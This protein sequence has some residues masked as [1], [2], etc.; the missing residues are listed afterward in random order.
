MLRMRFLVA[1][2]GLVSSGRVKKLS[3]KTSEKTGPY[4]N[5]NSVRIPPP[6]PLPPQLPLGVNTGL[7]K[8]ASR[9]RLSRAAAMGRGN[10]IEGNRKQQGWAGVI[11]ELQLS[12]LLQKRHANAS[13]GKAMSPIKSHFTVPEPFPPREST[14]PVPRQ[15][16]PQK[17]RFPDFNEKLF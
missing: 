17:E 16:E 11:R 15:Y 6:P 10:N 14:N 9:R 12:P 1:Y 7:K 4:T 5:G 13:I 3:S 2:M 8:K